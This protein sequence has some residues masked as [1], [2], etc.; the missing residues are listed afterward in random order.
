MIVLRR[1]IDHFL[2]TIHDKRTFRGVYA[3]SFSVVFRHRSGNPLMLVV[4]R[5]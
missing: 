3:S 2:G 5:L 4:L 1:H